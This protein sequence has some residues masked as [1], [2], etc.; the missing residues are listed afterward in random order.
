MQPGSLLL[1]CCTFKVEGFAFGGIDRTWNG[2]DVPEGSKEHNPQ[3]FAPV[4]CRKRLPES[5]GDAPVQLRDRSHQQ[6]RSRSATRCASLRDASPIR[7]VSALLACCTVKVQGFAFG[8]IDKTWNGPHV[9]EGSK[10]HNPQAYTH[11]HI[12]P[13][14]HTPTPSSPQHIARREVVSVQEIDGV[15]ASLAGLLQ[16]DDVDR[17]FAAGYDKLVVGTEH[18]SGSGIG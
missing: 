9:P 16:R 17:P 6:A 10:E 1:A 7:A 14:P 5:R 8:G 12:L 15:V 18:R 3:A 4:A 11:T 2:P 13:H